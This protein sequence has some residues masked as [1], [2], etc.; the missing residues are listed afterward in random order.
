MMRDEMWYFHN[1]K[2]LLKRYRQVMMCIDENLDDLGTTIEEIGDRFAIL[3]EFTRVEDIDLS[4][5]SLKNHIRC[6][7]RNRQMIHVINLGIEK[8][9][10]YELN[11][12]EFY[13]ILYLKYICDNSEKCKNDVEIIDRMCMEGVPISQ[14]TF[15]RR[16]NMAIQALSNIIWGYT[17]RDSLAITDAMIAKRK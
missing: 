5:V 6:M 9:R 10:K 13:W 12:E 8:L 2:E 3:S 16:L 1:T 17:A 11:G 4:E 15:Y 14:S 7:E